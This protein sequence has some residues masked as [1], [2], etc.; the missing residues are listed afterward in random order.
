V[1]F[2]RSRFFI[3]DCHMSMVVCCSSSLRHCLISR[4]VAVFIWFILKD[5]LFN[6]RFEHQHCR[7]GDMGISAT[8]ILSY[9]FVGIKTLYAISLDV[10]NLFAVSSF[11]FLTILNDVIHRFEWMII[12]LFLSKQKIKNSEYK[13]MNIDLQLIRS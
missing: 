1:I 6:Q 10:V 5:Q 13:Q 2:T 8:F 11:T 7:F 12:V 3:H 9:T 4:L